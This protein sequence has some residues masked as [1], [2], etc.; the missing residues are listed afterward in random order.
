MRG[1]VCESPS[2]ACHRPAGLVE[3]LA[4]QRALAQ[5]QPRDDLLEPKIMRPLRSVIEKPDPFRR[6]FRSM[7]RISGGQRVRDMLE[8]AAVEI[9]CFLRARA[10]AVRASSA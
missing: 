3:G 5:A 9:G 4:Q 8:E 2:L 10:C 7:I 1:P 6:Q